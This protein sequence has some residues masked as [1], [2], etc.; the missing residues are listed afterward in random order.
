MLALG[1][2]L[3]HELIILGWPV[4]VEMTRDM[5]VTASLSER[6]CLTDKW[7]SDVILHLHVNAS[8]VPRAFGAEVYYWPG[9]ERG[10]EI[11]QTIINA[12]PAR[13]RF[14]RMTKPAVEPQS[15]EDEYL[16][17]VR[18]VMEPHA[19][20]SCLVEVGYASNVQ[21]LDALLSL[22]VQRQIIVMLL[23]G[24]ARA[25]ELYR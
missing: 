8:P 20:T 17:R 6:G 1:I 25:I 11:S 12:V 2:R 23:A 21:N 9:N 22:D 18:N 4:A 7:Q 19:G 3:R 10:H 24:V 15:A 16:G 5:D 13:L 14:G